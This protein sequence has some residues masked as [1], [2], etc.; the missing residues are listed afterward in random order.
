M[1]SPTIEP[2]P[3]I[4]LSGTPEARGRAYGR[5]AKARV[6]KSLAHYATQLVGQGRDA[7]AVR[8]MAR[9]FVPRIEAFEP[10]FVAEMRGIAEGADV[11]FAGAIGRES[12]EAVAPRCA[13]PASEL[14]LELFER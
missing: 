12:D 8:A 11:A 1:S 10:A 6:H 4:E 9:A 5:M 14:R 13:R 7:G 2:F 3:L